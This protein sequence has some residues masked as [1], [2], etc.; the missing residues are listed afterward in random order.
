LALNL[1]RCVVMQKSFV[2]LFVIIFSFASAQKVKPIA[3]DWKKTNVLV[4]TKNGK[5]YVHENIS[6]AVACIKKLGIENGFSVD[7]GDDPAVFTESN[8]KKYSVIIFA[9]T[10]NDVFDTDDQRLAFRKYIE[11]G[12]GFVGVHSIVGTERNWKW[13]KNMIGGTFVW[14]PKFQPYKIVVTDPKHPAASGLPAVWEKEDEC[15]FEKEMNPSIHPILS[16]DIT[17][18]TIDKEKIATMTGPYTELYPASWWL[19]Y[20]GG[21]VWITALGHDKKDYEDPIFIKH[22]FNGLTFV[23]SSV[24]KLDA[25]KAYASSRDE[26]VR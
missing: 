24:K 7:A 21:M 4:Y 12:G 8:L 25:R 3:V 13:F 15:Y 18:L 23:A 10:N 20:D 1:S 19:D 9:S 5:G 14:H 16:H 17:S 11:S 6:S 26:V 2:F 22:L